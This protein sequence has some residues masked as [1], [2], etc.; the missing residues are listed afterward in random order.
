MLQRMIG[1]NSPLS[2]L[3]QRQRVRVR[4]DTRRDSRRVGFTREEERLLHQILAEPMDYI[5]SDEFTRPDAEGRIY[6]EA[7]P[8]A[9]PDVSWYRPLMDDPDPSRSHT[10]NTGTVLLTAAQERV[11]FLQYNYSRYR[12][13]ELQKEIGPSGPTD[14]QA[15]ELLR[16][17]RTAVAY[18]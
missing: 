2:R 5:N 11:L 12:I 3:I 13:A 10:K 9:R 6:E 17:Y 15:Q 14:E 16:W 8:I 1:N 18:R 7:E 4:Q